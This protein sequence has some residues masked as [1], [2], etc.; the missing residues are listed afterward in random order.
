MVVGHSSGL[1]GTGACTAKFC[2]SG[3]EQ[4][5][6]VLLWWVLLKSR[7]CGCGRLVVVVEVFLQDNWWSKEVWLCNIVELKFVFDVYRRLFFVVIGHNSIC[8][9]K[10]SRC[11][12]RFILNKKEGRYICWYNSAPR[13]YKGIMECLN[14]KHL[15][16][17]LFLFF[18]MNPIQF[19][20]HFLFY[21][22]VS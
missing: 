1:A 9:F 18:E 13:T 7:L 3:L 16:V 2:C 6:R 8:F 11:I 22:I 15:T 19:K 4:V 12:V 20:L 10:T 14:F 5:G 21:R 17:S